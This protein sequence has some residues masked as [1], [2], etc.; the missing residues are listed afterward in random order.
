MS[1]EEAA[2][3]VR[4]ERGAVDRDVLDQLDADVR[5][6]ADDYL[7]K[8]PFMMFRP[9]SELRSDVF[10]LLEA[11]QRP[12]V[13]PGLYRVA[14]QLCA[15]LAH[16]CADLGQ[17]YAADTHTRTAWLCADL[18]EDDQL[19]AYIRWVQS[20][21]A[22]WNGDFRRAAEMAHSG[23]RYA[24]IGTSLLRL[25]SQEARAYAAAAD[26]RE[27]ERALS[28][29]QAARSHISPGDDEPGG[30]FRFAAGKAAYYASEVRIALGGV[31]NARKAA[32]EAEQAL[33]IFAQSDEDKCPEFVAAAQLDLVAAHLALSDLHGAEEHLRPVFALPTESRTLPVV[34]RFSTVDHSLGGQK[35]A[36]SALAAELRE[37]IHLFCAYTATRE[38]PAV[39][40]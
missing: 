16:A 40:E 9:V 14:G 36:N 33:A 37:R 35:F 31:E 39:A 34:K 21:V 5:K 1:A 3:F 18:A 4:R 27:A 12:A 28:T 10:D 15:L 17:G 24:N 19:R 30:V 29:S 20:N 13:L 22:Y 7:T 23:Q 8:P 6:M 26:H 38:L 2:R 25:A 32:S 11:R